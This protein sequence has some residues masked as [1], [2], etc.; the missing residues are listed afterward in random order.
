[1]HDFSHDEAIAT[2]A[3]IYG[4]G[5]VDGAGGLMH[6]QMG[7]PGQMGPMMDPEGQYGNG[8]VDP[9]VDPS[10]IP[11][12]GGDDANSVS[13]PTTSSLMGGAQNRLRE[14]RMNKMKDTAQRPDL[15]TKLG[16]KNLP[17]PLGEGTLA[18]DSTWNTDGESSYGTSL[19]SGSSY[20]DT[21]N[22]NERNS[23]RALILQMAKAR[24]KSSKEADKKGGKGGNDTSFDAPQDELEDEVAGL[25]LD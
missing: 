3:G 15:S 12:Q 24:M 13:N 10:V 22:P 18:E 20:T 4:G 7:G 8:Q 1:M 5:P 16:N 6:H 17:S 2:R 11:H 21:T 14:K 25:E 9:P 23:R 19:V